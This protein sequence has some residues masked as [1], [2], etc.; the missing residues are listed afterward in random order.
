MAEGFSTIQTTV[1]L[2]ATVPIFKVARFF[3]AFATTTTALHG[4]ICSLSGGKTLTVIKYRPD[5][6]E[7]F[8]F[9]C[10]AVVLITQQPLLF[11]K[12]DIMSKFVINST[13]L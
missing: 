10:E 12:E 1:T 2:N 7:G 4:F 6:T 9:G 13:T 5:T 3:D 8:A 11:T